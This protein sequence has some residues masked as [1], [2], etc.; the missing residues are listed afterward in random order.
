MGEVNS[1]DLRK[2]GYVAHFMLVYNNR[3]VLGDCPAIPGQLEP[4][5]TVLAMSASNDGLGVIRGDLSFNCLLLPLTF[6]HFGKS[7]IW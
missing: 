1:D 2:S 4:Y 5:S 6:L 3:A 7:K